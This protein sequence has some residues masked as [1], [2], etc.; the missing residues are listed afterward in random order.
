MGWGFEQKEAGGKQTAW[1]YACVKTHQS[2]YW[3]SVN[4]AAL[5]CNANKKLRWN[6]LMPFEFFLCESYQQEIYFHIAVLSWSTRL[7]MIWPLPA[8]SN[9]ICQHSS[10]HCFSP[11]P[12]ATFQFSNGIHSYPAPGPLHMLLPLPGMFLA[13]SFHLV[14]SHS[15]LV[16]IPC[17][18]GKPYQILRNCVSTEPSVGL[19]CTLVQVIH[20]K[21]GSQL[22]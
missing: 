4:F 2:V 14:N 11:S 5:K 18:A 10:C 12:A 6:K 3:R 8:F 1:V 9:L 7:H 15:P 19:L 16:L 20:L 13:L 21:N 17:I 22:R